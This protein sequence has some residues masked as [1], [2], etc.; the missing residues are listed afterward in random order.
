MADRPI[1]GCTCLWTVTTGRA[2][3]LLTSET[4]PAWPHPRRVSIDLQEDP[5]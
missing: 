1:D 4:C 2:V 3:V 5:R